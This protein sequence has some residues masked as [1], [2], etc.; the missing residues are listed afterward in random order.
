MQQPQKYPEYP[1]EDDETLSHTKSLPRRSSPSL[2]SPLPEDTGIPYPTQ[3]IP[4]GM[5]YSPSPFFASR[6]STPA[7]S[8]ILERY[9]SVTSGQ[10]AIPNFHTRTL[11]LDFGPHEDLLQAYKRGSNPS[12]AQQT[13]P[14][15]MATSNQPAQQFPMFA[16][17]GPLETYPQSFH[18]QLPQEFQYLDG[19]RDNGV[20]REQW[21]GQPGQTSYENFG[22]GGSSYPMGWESSSDRDDRSVRSRWQDKD[23]FADSQETENS[24]ASSSRTKARSDTEG[25]PSSIR[26]LYRPENNSSSISRKK[27]QG[28]SSLQ[29]SQSRQQQESNNQFIPS[30]LSQR[31]EIDNLP[32]FY[33]TSQDKDQVLAGHPRSDQSGMPPLWEFRPRPSTVPSSTVGNG[34]PNKVEVVK[35]VAKSVSEA[36]MEK[37]STYQDPDV[38]A[39]RKAEQRKRIQEQFKAQVAK[40]IEESQR[41]IEP[42]S[43][44]NE[45]YDRMHKLGLLAHPALRLGLMHNKVDTRNVHQKY[46]ELI[47][48]VTIEEFHQMFM[49][50]QMSEKLLRDLSIV[51]WNIQVSRGK[52]WMPIPTPFESMGL[53]MPQVYGPP[54]TSR[55]VGLEY[56]EKEFPSKL[57]PKYPPLSQ[58]S[59]TRAL[60]LQSGE[61]SDGALKSAL[62]PNADPDGG[63]FQFRIVPK[64]WIPP[65]DYERDFPSA[66]RWEEISILKTYHQ[67]LTIQQHFYLTW[68]NMATPFMMDWLELT[69]AQER[70]ALLTRAF[71]ITMGM[72]SDDSHE[73]VDREWSLLSEEE[74]QERRTQGLETIQEPNFNLADLRQVDEDGFPVPL[75]RDMYAG[76]TININENPPPVKTPPDKPMA[77]YATFC[78]EINQYY[79]ARDPNILERFI[80]QILITPDLEGFPADPTAT[81]ENYFWKPAMSIKEPSKVM[82]G[83][84]LQNGL[85]YMPGLPLGPN[86]CE[87]VRADRTLFYSAYMYNLVTVWR[88]YH[89]EKVWWYGNGVPHRYDTNNPPAMLG[90]PKSKFPKNERWMEGSEI[91]KHV[92]ELQDLVDIL[93]MHIYI[94]R[95]V[96]E[97]DKEVAAE[98]RKE[99]FF[100]TIYRERAERA[101]TKQ[102]S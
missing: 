24:F 101:A 46:L 19:K 95:W 80:D 87:R 67:A 5:R 63:D 1:L 29:L 45:A 81:G 90:H 98:E 23:L 6:T 64:H 20:H 53:P 10:Y 97:D 100:E 59:R 54:A 72:T 55:G 28:E 41:V 70:A 35:S 68:V 84:I 91:Q 52:V 47:N 96:P 62:D 60:Q 92:K 85:P 13:A 25:G 99:S 79:Q 75:S 74:K 57:A 34:G 33:K 51:T 12:R 66:A 27:F 65:E 9:Q 38:I 17:E 22:Y 78:H 26:Q 32:V 7:P 93:N 73:W 50:I 77:T 37:E 36:D 11:P 21:I 18:Q 8:T 58:H 42:T 43:I 61:Y 40:K 15:Q 2:L 71:Y 31:V 89:D 69:M 94:E 44:A 102:R 14:D 83:S 30:L 49:H 39:A 56:A 16:M 82:L 88:D 86:I 3:H 4:E 48:G 76:I